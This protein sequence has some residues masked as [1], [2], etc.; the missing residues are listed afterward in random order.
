MGMHEEFEVISSLNAMNDLIDQL[1][2][3]QE[4]CPVYQHSSDIDS[5]NSIQISTATE[6]LPG[7]K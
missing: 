6:Q 3:L 4:A 1:M 5:L 2:Y 7:K